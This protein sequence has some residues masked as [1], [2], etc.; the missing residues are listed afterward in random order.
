LK[1]ESKLRSALSD[2]LKGFSY[3]KDENFY[4]KHLTLDDYVDFECEY[5]AFYENLRKKKVLNNE[6]LLDQAK[7]KD[8][9]SKQEDYEIEDL[10]RLIDH[11]RQ[12]SQKL[13]LHSQKKVQLDYIDELEQKLFILINKKNS[14]LAHSCES[15]ADRRLNEYYLLNSLF[16]DKKF[17]EPLLSEDDKQDPSLDVQKYFRIHSECL[18]NISMQSIKTVSTKEFF[19]SSWRICNNAFEYFGKPICKLSFH[20]TN[21]ANYA[22]TFTTIFERYPNIKSEDPDEIIRL[23]NSRS[24]LEEVSGGK[25]VDVVGMTH[26][27]ADK[28]GIKIKDRSRQFSQDAE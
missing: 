27:E 26:E 10:E 16:K 12:S 15:I 2:I 18:K 4:I 17:E 23:A 13:L 3:Y 9:W 25:D 20:Q 21:L 1:E 6:E 7:S 14:F 22:K 24:K 11:T 8:L 19:T 5:D 28:M